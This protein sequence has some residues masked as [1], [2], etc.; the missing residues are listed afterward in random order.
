MDVKRRFGEQLTACSGYFR[1]RLSVSREPG[2]SNL[3]V[4][5]WMKA[6]IRNLRG[7]RLFLTVE[8][9]ELETSK[10]GEDLEIFDSARSKSGDVSS[11][12]G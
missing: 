7:L 1:E 3:E 4:R 10:D 11:S 5:P 8:A 2:E 12:P 6:S 9:L